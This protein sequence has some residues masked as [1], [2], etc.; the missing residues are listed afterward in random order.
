MSGGMSEIKP[1]RMSEFLLGRM[2]E[3]M[4][5]R[6]SEYMWDRRPE[7]MLNRMPDFMLN[8]IY[9]KFLS[10]RVSDSMSEVMTDTVSE[11]V[12][13]GIP[14]SEVIC[15]C[16]NLWLPNLKWVQLCLLHISKYSPSYR[17]KTWK[18]SFP[19]HCNLINMQATCP[20]PQLVQRPC[21]ASSSPPESMPKS[22]CVRQTNFEEIGSQHS[23]K[24]L[25]PFSGLV[26]SLRPCSPT[27]QSSPERSPF[28]P[29]SWDACPIAWELRELIMS[30]P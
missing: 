15:C 12:I 24:S 17:G 10:G 16:Q 3:S 13:A 11:N 9:V 14:R 27:C 1:H 4:P 8:R 18:G 29:A 2:S 19:C 5:D 21:R 7:F 28:L 30:L 20:E 26:V 23:L 22:S 25:E 6:A